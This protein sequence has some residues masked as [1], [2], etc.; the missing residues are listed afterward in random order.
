MKKN[1]QLRNYN[2]VLALLGALLA[3][4]APAAAQEEAAPK[5]GWFDVAEF[6][7]FAS[8]GNSEV[9]TISLRNT[10]TRR[11]DSAT[12]EIAAGGV[13]AESTSIS[14]FAVGTPTDFVVRERST[15]ALTAENY[16]VRSRYD[17]EISERFF[18]FGGLGWDRN[19]FAGIDSRFGASAGVGHRWFDRDDAR[20]R[21]DYGVTYTDQT[22]VSGAS[23]SFAGLRLSY[24]Y[25]RQLNQ[26]TSYSSA[27]AIDENLDET[28]D[29]RADFL[30]SV[31]VAMS[32]RLALKASL[33][34]LYDNQPSLTNVPLIQDDFL[35][36]TRVLVELDNLDS[37]L[38]VSLVAN[39]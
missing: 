32:A 22:D 17:H 9:Q 28:R 18:W 31:S 23:S 14:R 27:L 19:E 4:T 13:R 10:A 11:W 6:G 3:V 37:V 34:L 8:A 2:P 12:L 26:A 35:D 38:T 21:T 15:T 33:Q 7:L 20:F 5:L 16:F 29:Y 24:D 30:N 36:G 39:F 25:W 1:K